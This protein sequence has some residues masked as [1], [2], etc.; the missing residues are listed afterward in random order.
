[1]SIS[2]KIIPDEAVVFAVAIKNNNIQSFPISPEAD[3]LDVSAEDGSEIGIPGGA[4]SSDTSLSLEVMETK[5]HRNNLTGLL[6]TNIWSF[7]VE[8]GKQPREGSKI[9]LKIGCHESV[10]TDPFVVLA[11]IKITPKQPSDWIPVDA[12]YTKSSN[13][14][15]L[16]CDVPKLFTVCGVRKSS[17]LQRKRQVFEAINKCKKKT[18]DVVFGIMTKHQDHKH[19]TFSLVI[20]CVAPSEVENRQKYWMD[21]EYAEEKVSPE[22]HVANNQQLKFTFHG[23]SGTT[24]SEVS[25]DFI[26]QSHRRTQNFKILEFSVADTE[27]LKAGHVTIDMMRVIQP[28]V[29]V[30]LVDGVGCCAGKEEKITLPKPVTEFNNVASLIVG[31]HFPPVIEER[32]SETEDSD[33]EIYEESDESKIPALRYRSL[34]TLANYLT[35]DEAKQMAY[36]FEIDPVTYGRIMKSDF[37]DHTKIFQVLAI[38]RGKKPKRKK[39]EDLIKVLRYLGKPKLANYV[40]TA[41]KEEHIIHNEAEFEIQYIIE[42]Y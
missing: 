28:D 21:K 41:V 39:S 40:E 12:K 2:I 5:D 13:G 4:F 20:E 3:T 14:P 34:K 24:P 42:H 9:N 37:S 10:S 35:L 32:E 8:N 23:K 38:W 11:S 15:V 29:I 30:E 33:I 6:V 36:Q 1:M 7:S 25:A 27:L 17:L 26:Y 31:L 22:F 16:V 18:D 19:N